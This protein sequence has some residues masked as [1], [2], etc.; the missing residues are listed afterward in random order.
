MNDVLGNFDPVQLSADHIA[1][2]INPTGGEPGIRGVGHTLIL[3]SA[4]QNQHQHGDLRAGLDYPQ[5]DSTSSV[6]A[7]TS[8]RAVAYRAFS[9]APIPKPRDSA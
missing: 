3:V 2:A 9:P 7:M 5:N 8:L 6:K 1:K 4:G